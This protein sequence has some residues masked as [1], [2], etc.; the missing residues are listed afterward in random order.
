MNTLQLA[1]T[2]GIGSLASLASRA[3]DAALSP[4]APASRRVYRARIRDW[5]YWSRGS[6]LD[7]EH[8][9]KYIRTLESTGRSAQVR[10]QALAA[11]KKLAAEAGELGWIDH[12]SASQ[13]DRIKSKRITGIRTGRWLTAIQTARLIESVDG[14]TV[15]GKRDL[16]ALALLAGCGLRRAEACAL[17]LEQLRRMDGKLY[18][19]NLIGKGGRV[20]SLSVPGWAA[21]FINRWVLTLTGGVKVLRSVSACGAING[22]LS[23]SAVRDIVRR[24]G[25]VIGV[26]D[27]NPHD[28][29]RTFAKLSRLGGAPLEAIQCS[30]G[31]AS[32]KTTEL[33]TRCGDEANAGDFIQLPGQPTNGALWPTS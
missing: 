23:P 10:N 27:L 6:P 29:R 21:Q 17:T 12:A 14:T 7:R 1:P 5:L 30:L 3:T 20:R 22:S 19:A 31:H 15:I 24:Y 16:A 25:A 11:L 18:L 9:I 28:L 32:V 26:P 4:L 2:D 8:V 33:Y 13:I